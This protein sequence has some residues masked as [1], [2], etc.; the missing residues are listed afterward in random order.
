ME[1]DDY[2]EQILN[3]ESIAREMLKTMSIL[4]NLKEEEK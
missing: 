4:I 1:R 3:Q 2:C